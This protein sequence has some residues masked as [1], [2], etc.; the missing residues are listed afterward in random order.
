MRIASL[1]RHQYDQ[2]IVIKWRWVP[3]FK[4]KAATIHREK[5]WQII[6]FKSGWWNEA[7]IS[8]CS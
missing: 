6:V 8:V 1:Q 3:N 2:F 5:F 7:R 4:V